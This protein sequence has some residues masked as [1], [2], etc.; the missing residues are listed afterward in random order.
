MKNTDRDYLAHI[1]DAISDI[2]SYASA[3][4]RVFFADRMRQD[5]VI[6]K[7]AIIGEAVRHLSEATKSLAPEVPWRS[8][9]GTRDRLV[10]GYFRVD[11][12]LIWT[13]ITTEL[14]RLRSAVERLARL[15]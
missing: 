8:I 12:N 3:G 9:V 14:P 11:L 5:A 2:E 4:H 6:R 13:V 15:E 1:L 7:T 10:H